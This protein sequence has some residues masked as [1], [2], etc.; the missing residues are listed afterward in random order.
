[1]ICQ[2]LLKKQPKSPRGGKK[3]FS[4]APH[5]Y[6]VSSFLKKEIMEQLMNFPNPRKKMAVGYVQ[7]KG[8]PQDTNIKRQ[9]VYW[10]AFNINKTLEK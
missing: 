1:M 5:Y 10:P 4:R 2:R 9:H 8:G 7:D 6:G 3:D